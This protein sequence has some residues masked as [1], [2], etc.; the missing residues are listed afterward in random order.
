MTSDE[1]AYDGF[2]PIAHGEYFH[3]VYSASVMINWIAD[4]HL[5]GE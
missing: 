3:V 2:K 4:A 1:A 5:C